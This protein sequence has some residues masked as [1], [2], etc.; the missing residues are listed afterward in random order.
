[1][2]SAAYIYS[3]RN[4]AIILNNTVMINGSS[5]IDNTMLADYSIS[6]DDGSSHY[7]SP[8]SDFSRR[9]NNCR[10]MNGSS[11]LNSRINISQTFHYHLTD[12]VYPNAYNHRRKPCG[13]MHY[14]TTST[15]IH[16]RIVIDKAVDLAATNLNYFL[17]H[18]TVTTSTE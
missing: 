17:D 11:E 16:M 3:R 7:Y 8:L 6:I 9:R 12:S 15:F 5:G 14:I 13:V 1:M 18:F 2:R 4:M 10:R